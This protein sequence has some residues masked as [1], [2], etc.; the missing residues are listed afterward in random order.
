[1]TILVET[2]RFE[3]LAAVMVTQVKEIIYILDRTALGAIAPYP[4]YYPCSGND[5][6]DAIRLFSPD[7]KTFYFV[8]IHYFGAR[9]PADKV[10]PIL[11]GLPE[12]ELQGVDLHEGQPPSAEFERVIDERTGKSYRRIEPFTR[13]ER[14]VHRPSD[15]EIVIHRRRG[16]GERSLKLVKDL[17][18]FYYRGD[19]SEGSAARWLTV[20]TKK[21]KLRRRFPI[22]EVLDRIVDNGLI[23]TDGSSCEYGEYL[24]F[25][26]LSSFRA[27]EVSEAIQEA[28]SFT[29]CRGFS[30]RCIGYAGHRSGPTLIWQVKRPSPP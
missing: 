5:H 21:H 26:R 14:Y 25:K 17:G 9:D 24:E 13:S 22:D 4:L 18:I 11:E 3:M 19:S 7:V 2:V 20:N 27:E 23:V 30:Y 29:D 12:Y 10:R 1:M 6:L 28:N 16:D 15:Q 8:D